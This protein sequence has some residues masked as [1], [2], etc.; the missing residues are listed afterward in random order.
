M[1]KNSWKVKSM[2]KVKKPYCKQKEILNDCISNM[3]TGNRKSRI[4]SSKSTIRQESIKYDEV[5]K[6]GE[7]SSISTNDVIAGGATKDD[8]V[9]LY[10]NKFVGERGRKYYDKLMLLPKNGICPLCGKRTVSTLDHYLPKTQYPTY[11]IT[12]FNL[13][14]A[15]SDCNKAKSDKVITS[16]EEETI[17]PYYDDFDDEIWIKA[18][19]IEKFPIGFSF[20]VDKPKLW[21]DVKFKR[22]ENHFN[23]FHLNKLYSSHAA[24]EITSYKFMLK[25]LNEYGGEKLIKKD[26]EA[27]IES[28]QKVWLNSW[29]AAMYTSLLNSK[30]FFKTYVPS[31]I[32]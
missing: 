18:N 5:A 16:R 1:R 3:Q 11:A 10:T 6:D 7:L 2:I 17:H 13:V 29:E 14:A 26:L 23:I 21:N 32:K 9:W 4:L 19:L 31:E 12:P 15:C 27:R 30:W 28:K 20:C 22:S 8:M 24:S 25:T